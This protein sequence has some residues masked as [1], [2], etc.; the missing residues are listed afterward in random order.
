MK[1]E[2]YVISKMCHSRE[3]AV[4]GLTKL[5]PSHF[6]GGGRKYYSIIKSL[7]KLYGGVDL[8]TFVSQSAAQRI[9]ES[10]ANEI[11]QYA[12]GQT[13]EWENV[14]KEFKQ[15]S[16]KRNIKKDLQLLLDVASNGCS[17][18]EIASKAT[19]K[20][21][22]WIS[23]TEK[24][25]YSGQEIDEMEDQY[26]DPILTGYPIYDDQ[27]YKYGGNLRGQMK[28]VLLRQKHGKTRSACWE[29]AQNIRMGHKVLYLT[30]ESTKT[31][32]K[33]NIKQILKSDWDKF[34]NNLFVVDGYRMLDDLS[35]ITL[36]AVLIDN[37]EK[38]VIDYAQ[39]MIPNVKYSG[40]NEKINICIQ[41]F[42]H[43]MVKHNFHCVVLSQ[44]RKNNNHSVTKDFNGDPL[45]PKGWRY[46]PKPEDAYGSQELINACTMMEVGFRPSAY[47][48]NIVESGLSKR[49]L[50]PLK[51]E[52][53]FFSLYLQIALTRDNPEFLH[54][55]WRFTDSNDGLNDP[56]FI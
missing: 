20:A 24:R 10:H 23:D 46:V 12:Q 38:V 3:A 45:L 14:F 11:F 54:Q 35:S 6:T 31:K 52:D 56:T 43:L 18:S 42:R 25:Y 22:N 41:E 4:W 13:D 15:E 32:I 47:E 39:L 34:K 50:N 30:L 5:N 48:E 9:E 1:L 27:I 19:S 33:N 17:V 55:W 53:S 28:G 8:H 16:I 51:Q 7:Y 40:E 29:V 2:T 49:V 37:I 36:E 44:A 21:V 26:G